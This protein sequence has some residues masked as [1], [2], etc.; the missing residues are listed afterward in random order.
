MDKHLELLRELQAL[1]QTG[2]YYCH[3]NFCQER[4]E[5]IREIAAELL[6]ERVDLPLVNVKDLFCCEVGFQ[7]PKIDT[8]AA[9]I[10]G[11]KILLVHEA[12]GRWAMP[13]GWCELNMSPAENI[14]KEVREEAGFDCVVERI[15]AVHD[16]AKRNYPK[17]IYGVVKIIY[18]CRATGGDFVPN[19]ETTERKYFALD[20]L[21]SL[22]PSKSTVEMIKL[23]FEAV[24][25]K[26]WE[27]QFD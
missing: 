20:E 18:Q 3:G 6:A 5:R 2:L 4:Y 8:R 22:A 1:A 19:N 15:I 13:G 25:A 10:D 17:A 21:P 7:T 26:V 23:C 24:R 27:P 9:I 16:H 14:V 12:N 11:E